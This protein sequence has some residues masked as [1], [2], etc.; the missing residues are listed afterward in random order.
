MTSHLA[1]ANDWIWSP[2]RSDHFQR[3][4]FLFADEENPQ[5]FPVCLFTAYK[6]NEAAALF[7]VQRLLLYAIIQFYHS[8]YSPLA[9]LAAATRLRLNM[10]STTA[11]YLSARQTMMASRQLGT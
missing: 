4:D 10:L 7:G 11:Q 3:N 8:S 2:L 5:I 6:A 1:Q 9:F